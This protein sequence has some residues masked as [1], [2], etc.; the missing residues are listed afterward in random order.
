[1]KKNKK[2]LVVLSGLAS[3]LIPVSI[4]SAKCSNDSNSGS[5]NAGENSGG[6]S[7]ENGDSNQGD[8][9]NSNEQ[10]EEE[11]I[12]EKT[13]EINEAAQ[14]LVIKFDKTKN[15]IEE[16]L[17]IE[18]YHFNL[19]AK[20][21]F[22]KISLTKK[23]ENSVSL[24]FRLKDE[25]NNIFSESVVKFFNFE[26]YSNSQWTEKSSVVNGITA[27]KYGNLVHLYELDSQMDVRK[28][29]EKLMAEK[30]KDNISVSNLTI[31][32]YDESTG[33]ISIKFDYQIGKQT[34]TNKQATLSG[35]KKIEIFN[36]NL[37]TVSLNKNKLIEEKKDINQ[38]NNTNLMDYLTINFLNSNGESVDLIELTKENPGLY[39]FKYDVIFSNEETKESVNFVLNI[40]YK[41][42]ELNQKEQ[43]VTAKVDVLRKQIKDR[44]IT[45]KEIL[46][47]IIDN[48]LTKKEV[49][50]SGKFA[51]SLLYLF[52]NTGKIVDNYVDN[53]EDNYFSASEKIELA[54][55]N[56][57]IDDYAGNA[58][59]SFNL[60]Y[61]DNGEEINSKGKT[62]SVNG[63][64][65]LTNTYLD[66]FVLTFDSLSNSTKA[67][68]KKIKEEYLKNP[69]QNFTL[70]SNWI[71]NNWSIGD[72]FVFLRMTE[73]QYNNTEIL[74]YRKNSIL[75]LNANGKSIEDCIK[76][77]SKIDIFNKDD[78]FEINNLNAIFESITIESVNG[79]R[80]NFVLNTKLEIAIHSS[81]QQVIKI[82]KTVSWFFYTDKESSQ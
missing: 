59:I 22:E 2:L 13:R 42:K 6:N 55:Q 31:E 4:L 16:A 82:P 73:K 70:D 3:T 50:N 5:E 1:M 15:T 21:K 68:I 71:K 63:F 18:N 12:K 78:Y 61:N 8:N 74:E 77:G 28:A 10:T 64:K 11:R 14:K 58:K 9:G 38:L 51:S 65:K 47:Y 39:S 7:G 35:F 49:D 44:E 26:F 53:F 52:R 33:T 17:K 24:V 40:N 37:L 72:S 36:P 32:S 46:D 62:I 43:Q 60:K 54:N 45:K 41:K 69:S 80:V 75:Q 30:Q 25:Q 48:K 67:F 76:D 57:T 79:N 20:Y 29:I 27:D 81:Q 56:L 34:F 66:N 19:D 23:G